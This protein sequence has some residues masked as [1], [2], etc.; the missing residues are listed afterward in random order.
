MAVVSST[1]TEDSVSE[2]PH[3]FI[4]INQDPKDRFKETAAHFGDEIIKVV[5]AYIEWL[6]E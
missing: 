5:D 6:P 3:F 2:F 4:E 1:A